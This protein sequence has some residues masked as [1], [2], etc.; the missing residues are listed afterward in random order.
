MQPRSGFPI[1]SW[2]HSSDMPFWERKQ[3][4]SPSLPASALAAAGRLRLPEP[5]NMWRGRWLLF[6]SP[7]FTRSLILYWTY[8][9]DF[10]VGFEPANKMES[11]TNL[12]P[13]FAVSAK[14]WGGTNSHS[15]ARPAPAA[16][17]GPGRTHGW[18]WA[19]L[20]WHWPWTVDLMKHAGHVGASPWLSALTLMLEGTDQSIK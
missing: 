17:R 11:V 10:F 13:G 2:T 19:K 6:H 9:F 4:E 15:S 16:S 1:R 14:L 20:W 12:T 8:G 7:V 3:T 18:H 5:S